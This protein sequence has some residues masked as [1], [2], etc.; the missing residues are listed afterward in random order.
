MPLGGRKHWNKANL[1]SNTYQRNTRKIKRGEERV[2][3]DGDP[4]SKRLKK[5]HGAKV[6]H[7]MK[8][9]QPSFAELHSEVSHQQPSRKKQPRAVM[10]KFGNDHNEFPRN[11]ISHSGSLCHALKRHN[12]PF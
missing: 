1:A 8:H 3:G 6:G 9:S 5:L 4:R 11:N 12:V 2:I 7:I 10:E